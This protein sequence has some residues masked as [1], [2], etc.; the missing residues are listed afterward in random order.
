M[1]SCVF[2]FLPSQS[3]TMILSSLCH[4]IRGLLLL[5]LP[6]KTL[7]HSKGPYRVLRPISKES[8]LY[9]RT[10]LYLVFSNHTLS[11]HQHIFL[12]L[13]VLLLQH[14]VAYI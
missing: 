12:V 9:L 6:S 5:E 2:K 4:L 8:A 10:V 14:S 13:A 1:L 11:N 7:G 3:A